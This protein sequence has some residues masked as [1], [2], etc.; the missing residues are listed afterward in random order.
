MCIYI[1]HGN[2]VIIR[3]HDQPDHVSSTLK[4]VR[5]GIAGQHAGADTRRVC[6]GWG[7]TGVDLP[8]MVLAGDLV[9]A[10][11]GHDLRTLLYFP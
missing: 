3:Y 8:H 4:Y 5:F 9:M 11:V 1:F 2:L 7:H 10:S 6:Y